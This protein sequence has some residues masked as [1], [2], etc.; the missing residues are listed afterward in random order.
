MNPMN[1][2]KY[3]L[4]FGV[5]NENRVLNPITILK[6]SKNIPIIIKYFRIRLGSLNKYI[7]NAT[8]YKRLHKLYKNKVA[9]NAILK[10]DIFCK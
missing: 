8:K 7:T 1:V 3:R 9:P 6:D 10:Q 4:K 5:H 2:F